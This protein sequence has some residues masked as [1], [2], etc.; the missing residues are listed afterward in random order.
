MEAA[1]VMTE[2]QTG[3]A[4]KLHDAAS[5]RWSKLLCAVRSTQDS[6]IAKELAVLQQLKG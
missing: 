5:L 2:A 1:W 4:F 3:V 6:Q